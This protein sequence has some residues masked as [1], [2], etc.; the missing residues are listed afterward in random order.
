M[1][2]ARLTQTIA[3]G[4]RGIQT[5]APK[6]SGDGVS[7]EERKR[8][9]GISE[10]SDRT[11]ERLW[12]RARS[13]GARMGVAASIRHPPCAGD[14]S[15]LVRRPTSPA[16]RPSAE[17]DFRREPHP[18]EI[19]WDGSTTGTTSSERAT[20]EA[21][22]EAARRLHFRSS[23]RGRASGSVSHL[24]PFVPSLSLSVQH[25]HKALNPPYSARTNQGI[26]VTVMV[27]GVGLMWAAVSNQQYKGGYWGKKKP[28][29]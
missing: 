26:I 24:V 9:K 15:P 21:A 12:A 14:A 20:Y 4:A 29:A 3:K 22:L 13:E 10:R 8:S 18:P 7:P 28:A 2:T 23:S 17:R 25:A 1:F 16:L 6:L 27:L 5:S 19:E 11:R